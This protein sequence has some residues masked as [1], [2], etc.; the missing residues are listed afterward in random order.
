MEDGNTTKA[1]SK[2]RRL[3]LGGGSVI[4]AV[5]LAFVFWPGPKEPKYQGKKLSEWLSLQ[6]ERPKECYE[7]I[8]AIGTNAIPFLLRSLDYR[9]PPRWKIAVVSFYARHAGAPGRS[10]VLR[11]LN[12][13]DPGQAGRN[14]FRGFVILGE[15]ASGAV[16]DLASILER[17]SKGDVAALAANSLSYTGRGAIEPLVRVAGDPHLEAA[18]R[19]NAIMAIRNMTY[20]GTNAA[21]CVPVLVACV[22]DTNQPVRNCALMTLYAFS[23]A[24]GMPVGDIRWTNV[25]P[26]P[27]LRRWAMRA[28]MDCAATNSDSF[29]YEMM[30]QGT[31]DPDPAVQAEVVRYLDRRKDYL[32]ST[33]KHE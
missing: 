17:S 18:R 30:S 14:A 22:G 1:A 11:R 32:D 33:A 9:C 21:Q 7:A 10:F 13:Y 25:V 3:L 4:A 8:N 24:G 15:R 16:P 20:L 27:V 12:V 19:N 31:N 28:A 5:I 23:H 2:K 6:P 29:V 26:D